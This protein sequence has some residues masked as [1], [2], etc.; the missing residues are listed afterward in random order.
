MADPKITFYFDI[1]S[2][3]SCIAFHVLR[4]SPVFSTCEVEFVP[5]LFRDLMQ[6]CKNTPPIAVKNK[7]EWI[8]RERIYW[9]RR[10]NVPMSEAIP[11]GFP[12]PTVEAQLVLGAITT[13]APEKLVSV[14]DKIYRGFWENGDSNVLNFTGLIPIL[15][16]A[17]GTD[18]ASNI[19]ELSK[20]ADM[21]STLEENT[22]K[23][24]VSGAFGLPWFDCT[25][26]QGNQEG[27]WGI[28]HLGRLV[29]FLELD[30]SLDQAF[31]VLL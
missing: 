28:D 22:Q 20:T 7:F 21:K 6:A 12:A 11:K 16:E 25:N 3:F 17:L 30:A 4:N 27:F 5:I 24:F 31:R 9:A 8:N 13:H 15:E 23:A 26:S 1:G 18:S 14:T 19:V 29:D 10:F 2:P